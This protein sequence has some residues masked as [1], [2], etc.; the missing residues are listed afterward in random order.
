[1]D[2]DNEQ[3]V[4]EPQPIVLTATAANVDEIREQLDRLPPLPEGY[5]WG[6]TATAEGDVVRSPHAEECL[7]SHPGEPCPGYPHEEST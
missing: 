5:V 2:R 1:V 3:T 6:L 4:A 7:E